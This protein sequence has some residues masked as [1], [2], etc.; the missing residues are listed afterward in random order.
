MLP[1]VAA[2]KP[3]FAAEYTDTGITTDQFCPQAQEMDFNAILKNR[4]LE[5]YREACR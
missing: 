2:G 5:S 4:N 3:V 1:F